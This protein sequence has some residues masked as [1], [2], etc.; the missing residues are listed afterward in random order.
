[1][2]TAGF[3]S[4]HFSLLVTPL[5]QLVPPTLRKCVHLHLS[6]LMQQYAQ[7]ARPIRG[8]AY[9]QV[10]DSIF[11]FP[12]ICSVYQLKPSHCDEMWLLR[13]CTPPPHPLP[14]PALKEKWVSPVTADIALKLTSFIAANEHHFH[15]HFMSMTRL[16]RKLSC[17]LMMP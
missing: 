6:E 1:M 5:L 9:N 12:Y 17:A 3:T 8:N 2:Y 16:G 14:Q 4:P 15:F 7:A 10:I 13:L 11:A